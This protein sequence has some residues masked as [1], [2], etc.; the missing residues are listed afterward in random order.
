MRVL[1]IG[2]FAGLLAFSFSADL[3]ADEI[4]TSLFP[5]SLT[6]K[7]YAFLNGDI[8]DEINGESDTFTG[9]SIPSAGEDEWV[10]EDISTGQR[11]GAGFL[12]MFFGIGSFIMGDVDGGLELVFR[13]AIG[14]GIPALFVAILYP[15]YSSADGM[16]VINETGLIGFI[17]VLPVMYALVPVGIVMGIYAISSL[18]T[19]WV[20]GFRRPFLYQKPVSTANLNDVRN[21]NIGLLPDSS[22]RLNTLIAFTAHF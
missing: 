2:V 21:W 1:L 7:N 11:I 10:F 14:I 9:E 6:L 22:G 13:Q 20:Y 16:G 19:S 3:P 5:G 4:N 8:E 12:N 15:M 18:I 17:F